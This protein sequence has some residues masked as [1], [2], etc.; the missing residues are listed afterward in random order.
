[1]PVLR[2]KG[3]IDE[4]SA[5]AGER[6]LDIYFA[7]T[8]RD[9]GEWVVELPFYAPDQVIEHLRDDMTVLGLL[10]KTQNRRV[11]LRSRMGK[12]LRNG[13]S[14]QKTTGQEIRD[15]LAQLDAAVQSDV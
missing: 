7:K 2:F 4:E 6:I 5:E 9:D 15:V 10:E 14:H 13:R 12:R 1:M 8:Q 11:W 3:C